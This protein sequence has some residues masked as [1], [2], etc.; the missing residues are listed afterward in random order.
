[1]FIVKEN[2]YNNIFFLKI[3]PF[4]YIR[5]LRRDLASAPMQ[6]FMPSY[7]SYAILP[8]LLKPDK[9]VYYIVK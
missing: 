9:L 6:G 5:R 4:Y 1:M 2:I 7:Q 8:S 3:N